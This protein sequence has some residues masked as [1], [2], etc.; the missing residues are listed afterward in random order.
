M[1]CKKESPIA[2]IVKQAEAMKENQTKSTEDINTLFDA[3]MQKAFN[4]E[5]IPASS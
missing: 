5:L 1:F 2:E 3:L 4:G